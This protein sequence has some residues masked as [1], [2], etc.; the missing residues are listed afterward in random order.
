LSIWYSSTGTWPSEVIKL[1]AGSPRNS[2]DLAISCCNACG[3]CAFNP[4]GNRD[5]NKQHLLHPE[6]ALNSF[7]FVS[8]LLQDGFEQGAHGLAVVSERQPH[9]RLSQIICRAVFST[10]VPFFRALQKFYLVESPMKVVPHRRVSMRST[11]AYT[12]GSQS[13]T[14]HRRPLKS[15]KIIETQRSNQ[16]WRSGINGVVPC[17]SIFLKSIIRESSFAGFEEHC[18]VVLYWVPVY[19]YYVPIGIV[20][21]NGWD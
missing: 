5:C 15:E 12:I 6:Q 18:F 16:V 11:P 7:T 17:L 4:F 8:R 2:S 20:L 13:L 10:L 9:A 1:T 21:V 14:P 19:L 3:H